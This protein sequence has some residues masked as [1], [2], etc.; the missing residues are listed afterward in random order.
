MLAVS[1]I[2]NKKMSKFEKESDLVELE[3]VKSEEF[4]PVITTLGIIGGKW[5][6]GILW[7]LQQNGLLRF[8]ELKRS[9]PSIS[10][11]VLSQQ[12]R[13]LEEAG[14]VHREIF[15]EV[16]PRVEYRITDYGHSLTPVLNAMAHWGIQHAEME[17]KS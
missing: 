1:G 13:E 11:K 5:K 17:P 16:P 10:Q 7:M 14:I 8:G 12:L 2:K 6:P 4:C 9:I 15:A 3:Q